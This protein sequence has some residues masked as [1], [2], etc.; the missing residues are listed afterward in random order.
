MYLIIAVIQQTHLINVQHESAA[1][2]LMKAA[3]K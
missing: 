3:T 2:S 1:Q